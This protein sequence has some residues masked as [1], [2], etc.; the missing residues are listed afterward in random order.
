MFIR[1]LILS[2]LLTLPVAAATS[3]ELPATW[4]ADLFAARELAWRSYFGDPEALAAMLT[5]DFVA[6]DRGSHPF[7]SKAAV[8]AESRQVTAKGVRLAEIRFPDNVVQLYGEVAILYTT[9]AYTL[10]H[11]GKT[12]DEVQGR[13]TEL[14][15]W[16]G[17]RWLHTG[18]H[19]GPPAP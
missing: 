4:K 12:D 8:V 2:L 15:R 3:A 10:T 11:D 13:G 17:K 18:W 5:D 19:L 14:F 16:D 7:S 9:F 6:I 1:F